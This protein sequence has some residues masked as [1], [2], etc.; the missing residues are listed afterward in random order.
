MFIRFFLKKISGSVVV[1][2]CDYSGIL[3]D[4]NSN[5]NCGTA[6]TILCAQ[7]STFCVYKKYNVSFVV[8]DENGVEY[9]YCASYIK[10]YC[11]RVT[12]LYL[13]NEG[14][15]GDCAGNIQSYLDATIQINI[16]S[17]N[18]KPT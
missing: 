15:F 4:L 3:T 17:G 11:G 18:I 10:F 8:K 16:V 1:E 2:K 13:N 6:L 7:V 12:I 5:I 14:I 9:I